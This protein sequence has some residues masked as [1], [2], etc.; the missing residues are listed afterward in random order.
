LG[1][2]A[3]FTSLICDLLSSVRP[4]MQQHDV[5]LE[6]LGDLDTLSDRIRDEV[7]ASNTVVSFV[8]LVGIGARKPMNT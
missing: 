7:V 6:A 8:P 3:N 5:S 4:L 2:D 1:S